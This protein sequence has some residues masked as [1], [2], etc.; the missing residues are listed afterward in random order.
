MESGAYGGTLTIRHL[1]EIVA[2]NMR[3]YYFDS[4]GTLHEHETGSWTIE[5]N[6]DGY[7]DTFEWEYPHFTGNA[8]WIDAEFDGDSYNTGWVELGAN[9]ALLMGTDWND[10]GTQKGGYGD[11]MT[12]SR[13]FTDTYNPQTQGVKLCYRPYV[14]LNDLKYPEVW[15]AAI[16]LIAPNK[17]YTT[18]LALGSVARPDI[19]KGDALILATGA[20]AQDLI[21]YHVIDHSGESP[22]TDEIVEVAQARV[23]DITN[24]PH[25][26]SAVCDGTQLKVYLDGGLLTTYTLPT[27]W[28]GMAAGGLQV[29]QILDDTSNQTAVRAK[30]AAAEP[31]DG[32]S[33]DYIRFYK[34]VLTAKAMAELAYEA[35]PINRGVRYVR[36]VTA[37]GLWEDEASMPWYREAWSGTAWERDTT[38]VARPVEGSEV[39]L[40]VE[41]ERT[42]EVN[43][44]R[45]ADEGFLSANRFY[46]ALNI[47]PLENV[48]ATPRL[49]LKPIGGDVNVND[50]SEHP[51]MSTVLD[52]GTWRYGALVVT[53][54]QNDAIHPDEA[55]ADYDNATGALGVHGLR[56]VAEG[57]AGETSITSDTVV[58]GSATAATG[59]FFK[60]WT[61]TREVTQTRVYQRASSGGGVAATFVPSAGVVS[62]SRTAAIFIGA[63][64]NTESTETMTATRTF[65]QTRTI[66]AWA[67]WQT[68]SDDST[69]WSEWTSYD[70]TS[71]EGWKAWVEG[72]WTP[73]A[74]SET[75][76]QAALEF[77]ADYSL[78]RGREEEEVDTIHLTGPISGKGKLIGNAEILTSAGQVSDCVWVP[79]FEEGV[80]W[81]L[82]DVTE[83]LYGEGSNPNGTVDGLLVQVRQIPG[84]LYLDLAL[85]NEATGFSKQLWYRYGYP[86]DTSVQ[87]APVLATEADFA[88]AIAFQIRVPE[89]NTKALTMDVVREGIA[90]VLVEATDPT[91]PTPTLAI[92]GSTSNGMTLVKQLITYVRLEDIGDTP[93]F[94]FGENALIHGHTTGTYA[95]KN[96]T[97]T[98][99]MVNDSIANLE[100]HGETNTIDGNFELRNTALKIADDS[101]LDQSQ[102]DKHLWAK[103]LTMGDGATFR[104]H[105]AGQDNEVNG[106]VF[107]EMVNLEGNATL[108]GY[109]QVDDP[110]AENLHRCNFT[111][112]GIDGPATSAATLTVNSEGTERWICYTANLVDHTATGGSLGLK[113]V[114][115]GIMAFRS[116]TPPS[117]TGF[118]DIQQ[119]ILRVGTHPFAS[120]ALLNDEHLTA[121]IGHKGLHVAAGASLEPNHYANAE[122]VIACIPSGQTLSGTGTIDGLVRLNTGAQLTDCMGMTLRKCVVDGSTAADIQVV[123]PETTQSGAIFLH[124]L[125]DSAR[126]EVRRRF[127]A[128]CGTERWD[129][130]INHDPGE[131]PKTCLSHYVVYQPNVPEPEN[132]KLPD[133]N[134]YDA[135]VETILIRYYQNYGL[136]ALSATDGYTCYVTDDNYYR[137]N[138]AE[139]GNA[140]RCFSNI[141]TFDVRSTETSAAEDVSEL[142][143]AYEFGISD[144]QFRTFEGV[145]YM[146]L[147]I[148]VENTLDNIFGD[149]VGAN[150]TADFQPNT[151]IELITTEDNSAIAAI[152]LPSADVE[153]LPEAGATITHTPG[154]RYYAIP[155]SEANFPTGTTRIKP[156]IHRTDLQN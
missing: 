35:P 24:I 111:A 86:G 116:P 17:T 55:V 29:G 140:F 63:V 110:D 132:P 120:D 87:P 32:G 129:V 40:Y 148:R 50:Y 122:D 76:T 96:R 83:T 36:E 79:A 39:R 27:D 143:M 3:F 44:E 133:G 128:M 150:N 14:A 37:D 80:N 58:E 130:G 57:E 107:S 31:N 98:R 15:S 131:S 25:V 41:G 91:S 121:E 66:D 109:G 139:I 105:A 115:T 81:L 145:D 123:L 61:Q 146:V 2:Q 149:V 38:G 62:F 136:A 75:L 72:T 155:F 78:I 34:G 20:T 85:T 101:I 97:F 126:P 69:A 138:A 74:S 135:A 67:S 51:W 70:T 46:S 113:K 30:F 95:F 60:G 112:A 59:S 100:A 68:P 26:F 118:V 11:I 49:A 52:D 47:L 9:N 48:T 19:A 142:L 137:L 117:V 84:R 104:F 92:T 102:E 127:R 53:G 71:D 73:T 42:L 153:T 28:I 106:V 64:S 147:E 141:W 54:G 22:D 45:I 1:P 103:S 8:A 82:S 108:H 23:A 56:S 119:G 16:R 94:T 90:T 6:E 99:D 18:I 88:A 124:L 43:T 12:D 114:G 125:E 152:E 144:V 33:V 13:F 5:P 134:V 89:G 65:T 93:A 10:D 4:T 154:V 156:R 7:Y 21:L 77:H 151:A